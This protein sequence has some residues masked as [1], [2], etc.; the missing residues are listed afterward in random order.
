MSFW[1]E[2]AIAVV[3]SL[4]VAVVWDLGATLVLRA[5]G[6]KLAPL[7]LFAARR[8]DDETLAVMH[9]R[10]TYVLVSGVL[11]FAC[12]LFVALTFYD[13]IDRTFI[14]PRPFVT[15]GYVVGSVVVFGLMMAVGVWSS[16]KQRRKHLVKVGPNDLRDR[17]C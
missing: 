4:G 11:M 5:F 2:T 17:R 10:R 13:F 7:P 12:P 9:S 16:D 15:A 1:F 3:L 6:I 8:K 14:E